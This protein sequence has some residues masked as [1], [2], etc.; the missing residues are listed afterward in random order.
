MQYPAG[1]VPLSRRD[2]IIE[3][4]N[5]GWD[6]ESA[7]NSILLV[8]ATFYTSYFDNSNRRQMLYLWARSEAEL[9]TN[10]THLCA[11]LCVRYSGSL[12][13]KKQMIPRSNLCE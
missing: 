10:N 8:L 4:Q 2:F 9:N 6:Q 11:V 12:K 1:V 13:C 5:K 3:M 7:E